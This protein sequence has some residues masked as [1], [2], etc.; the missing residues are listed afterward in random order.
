MANKVQQT[1]FSKK[2]YLNFDASVSK[3]W[4]TSIF[5]LLFQVSAVINVGWKPSGDDWL[6]S[7]DYMTDTNFSIRDYNTSNGDSYTYN[8]NIKVVHY[9]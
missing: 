7:G 6:K 9:V 4:V 3:H 5:Y 8:K 1:E 2:M